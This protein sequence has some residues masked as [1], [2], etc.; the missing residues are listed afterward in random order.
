MSLPDAR[1]SRRILLS[2]FSVIIVTFITPSIFGASLKQQDKEKP[3]QDEQ[4]IRLKSDLVEVRAV[5]TD[6]KGNVIKNI[7]KESFEIIEEGKPQS[8]SFFSV[9]SLDATKSRVDLTQPSQPAQDQTPATKQPGRTVVFFVDTL[10]L[11]T[12]SYLRTRETLLKFIN[13]Q[14]TDRDLAAV[15]TSGGSAGLYSQFTQDKQILREAINRLS[16]SPELRNGSFYTPF[17]AA[18]V[19]ADAPFALDV[20]MS[21]VKAEESLPDDP[22]LQKMVEQRARARAREIISEAT[23]LRRATLLTLR[24]VAERLAE[25]PGQRLIVLLSDGFTMLDNTG[26]VDSSDLEMVAGRAARSGV[27]IYSLGTKGLSTLSFYDASRKVRFS[28]DPLAA[29]TLQ[30]FISAGDRE[31]ENG[32][33]RLAKR[34]GGEAFLTTNDLQGALEKTL[35]KNSF[36]Y[37]LSYY[38]SSNDVKSSP[39]SIKVRVKGHPEYKVRAQTGYLA[40]NTKEETVA[41][42][43]APE[44]RLLRVMNAPLATTQIEIDASADFLYIQSDGAQVSL[45]TYANVGKLKYVE[46]GNSLLGKLLVLIEAINTAGRAESIT[47]DTMEIRLTPEQ[48]KQAEKS[49]YRYT[50]RIKLKPG[51]YQIRVG[52][53]DQNAELVG[54]SST[55]VEVP[56]LDSKKVALSGIILAR[57]QADNAAGK[58]EKKNALLQPSVKHGT[59]LLSNTDSIVYY[60]RAYN[61]SDE[62]RSAALKVKAQVLQG[63]TVVLEDDWRPLK[64]TIVGTEANSVDLSG[65]L[66]L[67]TLKPGT[68]QLLVTVADEK[69]K[70]VATTTKAFEIEE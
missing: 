11:S 8:I 44:E 27:V 22:H 36:Y 23:Y 54:T 70:P 48:Y 57:T 41:E 58:D 65:R 1:Q 9:E 45:N 59:S 29:N 10:H 34:T 46:D 13:E 16:F 17:I 60:S 14:L 43:L 42:N 49:V 68:Y 40:G 15:V 18:K 63:T 24:G 39:R 69:A 52:V 50:K 7:D 47:Q 62:K 64:S 3:K 31:L 26:I 19:E 4:P 67:D 37:A 66:K 55:W 56:N 6:K 32:M 25:M 35:N 20:A 38:S 51:T 2:I 53:R 30:S 5:V 28:P 61:A 12:E 33:T 21:I